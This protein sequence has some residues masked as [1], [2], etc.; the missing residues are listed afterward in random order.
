[1]FFWGGAGGG[2]DHGTALLGLAESRVRRGQGSVGH[3]SRGLALGAC[4]DHTVN[5][6]LRL[7]LRSPPPRA[8][9]SPRAFCFIARI[10]GLMGSGL[11]L[12]IRGL[13]QHLR[14]QIRAELEL[15]APEIAPGQQQRLHLAAHGGRGQPAKDQGRTQGGRGPRRRRRP[16]LPSNA[17]RQGPK[18]RGARLAPENR[19]KKNHREENSATGSPMN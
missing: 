12:I 1:M 13:L 11:Y 2:G 7:S 4:A 18:Q 6:A 15:P 10:H 8:W 17:R 9:G 3:G 5:L 16:A 19:K 14:A